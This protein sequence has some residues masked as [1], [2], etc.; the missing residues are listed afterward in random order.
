[1]HGQTETGNAPRIVCTVLHAFFLGIAAWILFGGGV[2]RITGWIFEEPALAGNLSRRVVLLAFGIFLFIRMIVTMFYLL[3]RRF[4][5]SEMGGVLFA[6]I[7]YQIVFA[8][9]GAADE[10]A[11]T[12]LDAVAIGLFVLGSFL[13]TYSEWQR[14]QFK[15]K[16]ENSGRLYTGG[17]FRL[18]R[19]INYFGDTLWVLGWALVTRNLWSL[20]IPAW[21]VVMFVAVFI[22]QLSRHMK[23]KYGDEYKQWTRRSR[24]FIP[25]VY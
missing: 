7:L 21:L 25:F 19:H 18:A 24:R 5:W 9:L 1:M 6:L 20:L 13:N 12:A 10:G 16:P 15:G 22:P 8:L 4:D 14:K 3:R 2:E 17:L 23:T 11:L